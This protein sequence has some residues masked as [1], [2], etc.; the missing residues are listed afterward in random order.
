MG[1][2][3][4]AYDLAC[5]NGHLFEGWFE[6]GAAFEDQHKKGLVSCPV[7][8]DTNVRKIPSTFAIKC[9]S[10]APK[11][12]MDERKAMLEL[13]HQVSEY[14]EKNFDNVGTDFAKEAL[15]IHYGAA[16]PRNIRGTSSK[17]EETVLKQEGIPFFKVPAPAKPDTE[18]ESDS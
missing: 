10:A 13:V 17:E 16:E 15:K 7:C 3:M 8:D 9:G 12:A 2:G 18:S 4:I 5:S 11:Y 1:A 14:V 6:D